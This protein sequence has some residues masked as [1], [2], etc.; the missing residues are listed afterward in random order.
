MQ[1]VYLYKYY[2][3]FKNANKFYYPWGLQIWD[4]ENV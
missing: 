4:R 3:Y 2:V 1:V